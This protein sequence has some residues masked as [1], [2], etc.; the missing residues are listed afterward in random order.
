MW[1]WPG[2][3]GG[4]G[5]GCVGASPHQCL[6]L[7][8]WPSGLILSALSLGLCLGTPCTRALM[9][10]A[11]SCLPGNYAVELVNDS[12]YDWNVKLLK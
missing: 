4:V 3:P 7:A 5:H 1:W 9:I 8:A 6:S 2:A 10:P 11:S 12:L